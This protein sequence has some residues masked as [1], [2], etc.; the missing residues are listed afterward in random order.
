MTMRGHAANDRFKQRINDGFWGSL[1]IAAL[2]H[3][4]V[5]TLWP[6]MGV[7]ESGFDAAELKAIELPP[8]LVIP[9]APEAI[10]RP[11]F[12]VVSQTVVDEDITITPTTLDANPV[13]T[14]PP[15]PTRSASSQDIAQAPV[16]TPFTV[17]PRVLNRDDVQRTLERTYPPMLRDAGIGGRVDVW[18]LIDET[19][20]VVKY[21]V[22]QGS[23]YPML[24][25]AA[26]KVADIMKFSP[27]MNR[28]RAVQVWV[29]LAI[30]FTV[31][32]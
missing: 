23:D 31:G 13:N 22:N 7:A 19:G 6:A 25:A 32:R 9:P 10:T 18:F 17:A 1:V 28:D 26:L 11:A 30:A 24:D 21:Q 27:A 14:L 3:G 12:P 2:L 20:R 5:F 4:L 29:S 8:E 15:P 16:F